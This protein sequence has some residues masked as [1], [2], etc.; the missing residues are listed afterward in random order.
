MCMR[1]YQ[2]KIVEV[3]DAT[4]HILYRCNIPTISKDI[5]D[6]SRYLLSQSNGLVSLMVTQKGFNYTYTYI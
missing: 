4:R 6:G 5:I 3:M 2:Y 1:D